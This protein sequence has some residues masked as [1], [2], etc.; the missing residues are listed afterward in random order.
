M[1]LSINIAGIGQKRDNQVFLDKVLLRAMIDAVERY[2]DLPKDKQ[3]LK[4]ANEFWYRQALMNL[5]VRFPPDD[6]FDYYYKNLP[7]ATHLKAVRQW[8][9]Y[10]DDSKVLTKSEAEK[11]Y[12]GGW[13]GFQDF[14]DEGTSVGGSFKNVAPV[15]VSTV[16]GLIA[17]GPLG[18]VIGAATGIAK[19]SADAKKAQTANVEFQKLSAETQIQTAKQIEASEKA[20]QAGSELLALDGWKLWILSGVIIFMIIVMFTK[21]KK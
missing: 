15:I 13:V 9:D 3:G 20:L 18:A 4:D 5:T 19:Y 14:W 10:P 6:L 16:G 7:N 2:E 12:S 8:G 11:L 17:G 21:G 1:G